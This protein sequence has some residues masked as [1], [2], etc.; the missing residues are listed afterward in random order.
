MYTNLQRRPIKMRD[1]HWSQDA[2][3]VLVKGGVTPNQVSVMSTV[4][5][6]IGSVLL[7]ATSAMAAPPSTKA[8][9]FF[10]TALLIMLRLT[11]NLLDGLMAVEY[12]QATKC[13]DLFNELPDRFSD[14]VLLVAAGY[15]T[16][17]G[18]I[19]IGLGWLCALLALTTAYLRAFAARYSSSQDY[20]GPMAKQQRMYSLM[21]GLVIAGV[22]LV[23]TGG[24]LALLCTLTT[25]AIGTTITCVRRTM[26]LARQLDAS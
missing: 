19:G 5:A 2:A 25:M 9:A 13:G 21:F 6:A 7:I 17:C 4:F 26:N 3:A 14:S 8:L 10:V 18:E 1:S 22:Q 15:A 24:H 16:N 23:I 11:C 12:K 20:S